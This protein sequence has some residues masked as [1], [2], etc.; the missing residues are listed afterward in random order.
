MK[1]TKQDIK[2][3]AK[4]I[5]S[6]MNK[7]KVGD[8]SILVG[9]TQLYRDYN[10]HNKWTKREVDPLKFCEYF[11]EDFAMGFTVDGDAYEMFNYGDRPKTMGK[12]EAILDNYGFY[13]ECAEP[14]YWFAA[15][16]NDPE[17]YELWHLKKE[18][19]VWICNLGETID[20][21]VPG[22]VNIWSTWYDMA[23]EVGDVGACTLGE[24]AEFKYNGV[25]YRM[26]PATPYQ[27]DQSWIQ[28]WP[29]IK[30][31]LINAGCTDVYLNYGHLD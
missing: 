17:D 31:M 6:V 23:K 2:K 28:P 29:T 5:K 30:D 19:I 11:P 25:K 20:C 16:N 8:F 18:K 4:E 27:G 7:N 14:C 22:I 12:I 21:D 15:L 1:V 9:T 13:L 10:N 24:Y 26:C 3:M